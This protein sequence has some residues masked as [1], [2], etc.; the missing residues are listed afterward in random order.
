M[1]KKLLLSAALLAALLATVV[2]VFDKQTPTFSNQVSHPAPQTT[3]TKLPKKDRIDLAIAQEIEMTKDPSLGYVPRER[4]VAAQTYARRRQNRPMDVRTAIPGVSWEERGP[5]NVGGRT[6]AILVDPNDVTRETIWAA[7]VAGGLW[8]CSNISA[9]TPTWVPQDDFFDN[10]AITTLADDP[11]N[12]NV[13]YFGTG[14]G[15]FNL[16][17]VRGLGIWKTTDGGVNWN[18]LASTNNSDFYYVQKIVVDASGNVYAATRDDGLQKSTDGG[19][20]WSNV[21]GSGQ[22]A[23][24][25]ELDASGNIY[26]S[27]GI[28]YTDGL[29]KSTNGGSTWTQFGAAHSFPTTGYERIEIACAPSDVNRV[30][31]VLQDGSTN[32]CYGI[33]RT[34]NGGTSWTSLT[35]PS[36]FG[37]TNYTRNQAWYDLI[38]AVDPNDPDRVFIGGID[39]L[40]SDDAGA[41]FT[42]ITQWYGG[43]G[44]QYMHA[45]QHAIVFEAGNSNVAYFGNDGGVYRTA[46]ASAAMPSVEGRNYGY[47]VTQYYACDISPIA[48]SDEFI[49]GSQDNGTQRYLSV[50]INSTIEVTGGDGGFCHIDDDENNV[51]I[52]SSVY[53]QYWITNTSWTSSSQHWFATSG[54]FINPTDYDADAD[55]L[56]A[57]GN[58]GDLFRVSNVGNGAPVDATLPIAELGGGQISAV[59]VSPNQANRVFLATGGGRILRVDNAHTGTPSATHINNGAPTPGAYITCIAVEDG[60][61][62]HLLVTYSS[63]GV[64]SIW[65]TTNGGSTWV[66]KEGNLP[67]MPV[68][69][70]IFN[71]NDAN[72]AMIATEVG[73]WSTTDLSAGSVDWDPTNI[74]LANV[75]TDMLKVRESDKM[76]IAATHG[77]GLYSSDVFQRPEISFQV[78]SS[79][80]SEENAGTTISCRTYQDV[81]L[82]MVIAAHPTGDATVTLSIGG[83]ADEGSDYEVI[84]PGPLTFADG[85]VVNQ[86][87]TLRIFDDTEEEVDETIVLSYAISGTTDAMAGTVNQTHTLTI[88]SGDMGPLESEEVIF[89]EDFTAGSGSWFTTVSPAVNPHNFW[90]FGDFGCSQEIDGNTAMIWGYD[91]GA[92]SY[93]D[94]LTDYS[95]E[96]YLYHSIDATGFSDLSVSFDWICVGEVSYD[97]GKLVYSTNGGSSWTELGPDLVNSASATNTVVTLPAILNNSTFLLGFRWENDNFGGSGPGLGVDNIEVTGTEYFD[98]A[99]TLNGSDEVYLGPNAEVHLYDGGELIASIQNNSSHDFGCTSVTID[100][101]GNGAQEFWYSA[102]ATKNIADK[103][104]TVTP[105]TNNPSASITVTLYY[106]DAEV[107]GWETATGKSFLADAKV[108]KNPGNI[109]NV[110]PGTPFP[111][112]PNIEQDVVSSTYHP[113]NLAYSITATF[114]SGFS[115][116]GMG[117]PGTPPV[118]FPVEFLSFTATPADGKVDLTWTVGQEINLATYQIER[119]KEA[120]AAFIP[121]GTIE[122]QARS[123]YQFE[124]RNIAPGTYLYRIR[125]IDLNGT[126]DMSNVKRVEFRSSL[127]WSVYPNPFADHLNLEIPAEWEG[128]ALTLELS[129]L[130]GE[131][132]HSYQSEQA[133]SPLKLDLTSLNLPAGNYLVRV[134]GENT[135]SHT[136]SVQKR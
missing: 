24:D 49:A 26:A 87:I 40:V 52:S 55:I 120:E 56:Y 47:N 124:D 106:T 67:D 76:L 17:G 135:G 60:D 29:Y 16:D 114:N 75:R 13:M 53:N 31:A 81:T 74:G 42:Q 64:V 111:D 101:T 10:L 15:W 4:L 73:V 80:V 54:R 22:R 51:Q 107:S 134:R 18:Q 20:T 98:I 14:E 62:D 77:R 25:V 8:K 7:G 1:N 9:P 122:A 130:K 103:T 92:F 89:S 91:G 19:A 44:F 33:Y 84:T 70:A 36:A 61:D 95:S 119:K 131:V 72:Q 34:D 23:A 117:D 37:M 43:G 126:E 93:C 133:L 94:Y 113:S 108:I 28:F 102:D 85:S 96:A 63:Y 35:V 118:S 125:T 109:A 127:T 11:T 78:P 27:I 50:G 82:D 12:S 41:T 105:T 83:T 129:T 115:G 59:T 71:P 3:R 104:I 123:Q 48:G 32:E 5:N 88:E 57:A 66:N 110:T 90:G 65:E 39:L 99:S 128:S 112:G 68:R 79:S 6:R 121:V 46:N 116:F 69:W 30:Y 136:F 38:A 45:D 21:L 2:M 97:F 132:V 58:A 86:Q 100:R